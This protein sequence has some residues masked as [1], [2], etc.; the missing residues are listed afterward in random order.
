MKA[1]IILLLVTLCIMPASSKNRAE[2]RDKIEAML[3]KFLMHID[4]RRDKYKLEIK[5]S[6]EINAYASLGRRLVINT[7]LIDFLDNEV[8]LAFVVAH[9]LGHIEEKHV[10]NSIMRHHLF[11]GVKYL[12]FKKSA[13]YDGVSYLHSLHYS[14]GSEKEADLFAKDMVVEFYCQDP[15]KL[16]F[17]E[18]MSQKQ[19]GNKLSEYLSTHPHPQSRLD[20]LKQEIQDSGCK[21]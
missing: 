13:I 21:V 19:R 18:K 9:E 1:A 11:S 14:R 8:A 12:F 2:D 10:R 5:E 20:Y 15:G 17:F 16:E 3:S 6:K 4:Q 7:G